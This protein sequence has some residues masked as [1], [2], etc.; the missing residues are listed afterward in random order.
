VIAVRRAYDAV[1]A[2]SERSRDDHEG[3]ADAT[4]CE[5]RRLSMLLVATCF[6]ASRGRTVAVYRDEGRVGAFEDESASGKE[7]TGHARSP[8]PRSPSKRAL[9]RRAA[10]GSPSSERERGAAALDGWFGA[11]DDGA[12]GAFL[13]QNWDAVVRACRL[14]KNPST[15]TLTREE[16]ASLDFLFETRDERGEKKSIAEC[17]MEDAETIEC[18]ALREWIRNTIDPASVSCSALSSKESVSAVSAVAAVAEMASTSGQSGSK[19]LVTIEN[20]YKTTIVRRHGSRGTHAASTHA[21]MCRTSPRDLPTYGAE[22]YDDDAVPFARVVDCTDSIVYLLEPYDYV[23]I[24]GCTDCVVIVGAVSRSMRVEGCER[25]KLICAAK[26]VVVRSCFE[27]TFHLGILNQPMFVGDNRKCVLGPYNTFYE[28]LDE[29]LTRAKLKPEACNAWDRPVVLGADLPIQDG[30][31]SPSTPDVV[32]ISSGVSL[33]SPD[34]FTMFI[35]PFRERSDGE[36]PMDQDGGFPSTPSASTP[37]QANPFETPANY[38]AALEAKMEL[39]CE[40]RARVRDAPLSETKR[41]E[42]KAVIQSHFKAW[43]QSSGMSREIFDLS[44]VE[45]EEI[46]ARATADAPA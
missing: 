25:V 1:R 20:A 4:T 26:R 7:G 17:A 5:T 19:T 42:L 32:R 13:L 21:A 28:H 43:L 10:P 6:S 22:D 29:H 27:C 46:R 33:M 24:A 41:S 30:S 11:E 37:T 45:R 3:G 44:A 2:V 31:S 35:I 9:L 12:F 18:D 14:E 16:C 39:I 15:S 23:T 38:V 8:P 34:A 40:V 36:S